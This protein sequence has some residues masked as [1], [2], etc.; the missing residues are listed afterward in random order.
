MDEVNEYGM[1]SSL[2][3]LK[4]RMK[5]LNTAYYR[6]VSSKDTVEINQ[7]GM[8]LFLAVLKT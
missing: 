6:F 2:T 3:I 7:Y 1:P 8:L 4:I 5:S